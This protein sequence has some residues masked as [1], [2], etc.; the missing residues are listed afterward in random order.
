MMNLHQKLVDAPFMKQALAELSSSKPSDP[1]QATFPS[2][3][4]AVAASSS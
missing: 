3:Q 2:F 4:T 1:V